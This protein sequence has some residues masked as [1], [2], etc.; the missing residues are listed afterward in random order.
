VEP[1]LLYRRAIIELKSADDISDALASRIPLV[2]IPDINQVVITRIVL[3]DL[4]VDILPRLPGEG[5]VVEADLIVLR[6]LD[7]SV[8]DISSVIRDQEVSEVSQA[9]QDQLLLVAPIF[10]GSLPTAAVDVKQMVIARL[11]RVRQVVLVLDHGR[12]SPVWSDAPT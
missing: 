11:S 3:L 8:E 7:G 9:R 1:L 5:V 12:W 6:V 2:S 10:E 4:Q